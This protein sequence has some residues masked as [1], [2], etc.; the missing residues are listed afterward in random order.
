MKAGIT[1]YTGAMNLTGHPALTV[2]IGKVP[3]MEE[4]VQSEGDEEIRLPVGMMLVGKHWDE[5][6]LLALGDAW[7]HSVDWKT[8][9][10]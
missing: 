7:E 3:C 8:V 10:L 2:P 6:T 9:V 5:S 1:A 4:D